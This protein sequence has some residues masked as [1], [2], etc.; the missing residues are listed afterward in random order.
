M[1]ETDIAGWYRTGT[2]MGVVFTEVDPTNS[3]A[4]SEVLLN[5][6]IAAL[7]LRFPEEVMSNIFAKVTPFPE[8]LRDEHLEELQSA[9]G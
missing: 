8:N 1:R 6:T 3:A 5:K 7:S 2:V 9:A 4:I